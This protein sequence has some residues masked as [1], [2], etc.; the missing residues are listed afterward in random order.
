[1]NIDTLAYDFNKNTHKITIMGRTPATVVVAQVA[2]KIDSEYLY[3][4]E[5]F[6]RYVRAKAKV[7]L[8]D[9]LTSFDFNIPGGIKPNYAT[10]VTK[11]EAELV[12][13]ETM[14]KTENTGDFLY[15]INF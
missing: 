10:M 9:L 4:D 1:M 2:K 3:E 13:V 6:Q 11:A 15:L 12:A 14:M 5:L 7:K 8:G